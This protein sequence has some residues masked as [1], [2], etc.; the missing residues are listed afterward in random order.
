MKPLFKTRYTK[1]Q[2]TMTHKHSKTT[3]P[4][5]ESAY[6]SVII[7]S[8]VSNCFLDNFVCFTLSNVAVFICFIGFS[9]IAFTSIS[10]LSFPLQLIYL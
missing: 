10:E 2:T 7:L 6:V 1:R 4:Y 9:L 8:A 5:P 3:I